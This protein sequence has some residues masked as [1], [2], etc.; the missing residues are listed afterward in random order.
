[1]V[2]TKLH[3]V[4]FLGL[5]QISCCRMVIGLSCNI[6]QVTGLY[7]SKSLIVEGILCFSIY[8]VFYHLLSSMSR[9]EPA[10]G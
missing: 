8:G 3:P 1:M 7:A 2:L 10:S 4:F 6:E 5:A 9:T